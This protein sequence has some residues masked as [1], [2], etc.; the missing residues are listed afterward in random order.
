MMKSMI[1]N[2]EMGLKISIGLFV[3][4]ILMMIFG[5]F[6]FETTIQKLFWTTGQLLFLY[7]VILLHLFFTRESMS[8][9]RLIAYFSI[10]LIF[11]AIPMMLVIRQID[12]MLSY[13]VLVAWIVMGT[14]I[15][16]F[17]FWAEDNRI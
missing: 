6:F 13:I 11:F 12:E 5:L 2:K 14:G 9:Y 1:K 8:F 10:G 7:A 15:A 3:I 4:V 16:G 17:S